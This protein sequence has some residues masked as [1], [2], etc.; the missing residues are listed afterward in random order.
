MVLINLLTQ[1]PPLA[2]IIFI[3]AVAAGAQLYL[4]IRR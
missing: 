1:Y 3:L 4:A 2:A